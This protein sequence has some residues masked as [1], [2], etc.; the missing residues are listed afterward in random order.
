MAQAEELVLVSRFHQGTLA[1]GEEKTV[2]ALMII[3]P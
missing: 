2:A 1:C 3:W